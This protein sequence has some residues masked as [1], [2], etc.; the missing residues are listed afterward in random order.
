MALSSSTITV[1]FMQPLLSASRPDGAA[2]VRTNLIAWHAWIATI[3][4]SNGLFTPFILPAYLYSWSSMTQPPESD[5]D[6]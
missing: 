5:S 4:R 2:D 3:K 1:W 6:W